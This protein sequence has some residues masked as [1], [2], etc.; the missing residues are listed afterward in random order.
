MKPLGQTAL[1][2]ESEYSFKR[3]WVTSLLCSLSHPLKFSLSCSYSRDLFRPKL[4][5]GDNDIRSILLDNTCVLF[6]EMS[7]FATK[8]HQSLECF[9]STGQVVYFGIVLRNR[10]EL[11][12]IDILSRILVKFL[13]WPNSLF[14]SCQSS[15]TRNFICSVPSLITQGRHLKAICFTYWSN[16]PCPRNIWQISEES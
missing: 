3:D 12:G 14:C 11:R 10:I 16:M 2:W 8:Y 6:D 5:T 13:V 4:Q 9:K 7:A 15:K 1:Y